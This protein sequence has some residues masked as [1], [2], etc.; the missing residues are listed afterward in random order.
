MKFAIFLDFD[1]TITREDM[2]SW[3]FFRKKYQMEPGP[4]FEQ[5]SREKTE[6][7]I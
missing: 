2:N 4:H 1:G 5:Y 3:Q 7:G 6:S